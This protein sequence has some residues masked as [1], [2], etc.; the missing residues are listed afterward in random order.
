MQV[1]GIQKSSLFRIRGRCFGSLVVTCQPVSDQGLA[2][3]QESFARRAREQ[4]CMY[5]ICPV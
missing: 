2:A 3:R 1:V 4:R 5:H